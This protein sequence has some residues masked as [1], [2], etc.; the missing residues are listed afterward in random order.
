MLEVIFRRNTNQAILTLL[1]APGVCDGSQS[2][3]PFM[4][5]IITMPPTQR[6]Y[7]DVSPYA[8]KSVD[9]FVND[10]DFDLLCVF[11]ILFLLAS[12]IY[13]YFLIFRGRVSL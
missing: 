12:D 7:L 11:C 10:I 13:I 2:V 8:S 6:K 5:I 9:F 3:F 4:A 1:L